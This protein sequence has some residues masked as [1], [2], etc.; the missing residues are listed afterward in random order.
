MKIFKN[1]CIV[2]MG[3]TAGVSIEIERVSDLGKPN[4]LDAKGVLISTFTSPLNIA[5]LNQWFSNRNFLLFELDDKKSGFN[6]LKKEI[7]DGL[8][9]FLKTINVVDKSEEILNVINMT[10]DTKTNISS[11]NNTKTFMN[12][13]KKL[14][15][16]DIIKMSKEDKN[17]FWNKLMDKGVENLT[18]YDKTLLQ[19][20]SK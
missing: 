18:D 3:D 14:S 15:E 11:I 1:Y 7:N 2:I 20:L 17:D 16:E 13:D 12:V 6:I 4:I 9:G 8:F 5:E 10:S 19:I